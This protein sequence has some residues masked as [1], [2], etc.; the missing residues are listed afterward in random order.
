MPKNEFEHENATI[1]WVDD[2]VAVAFSFHFDLK[3]MECLR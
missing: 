1:G 3:I 2:A